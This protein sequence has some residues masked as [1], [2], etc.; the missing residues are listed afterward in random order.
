[1]KK[2]AR[3][4]DGGKH[5]REEEPCIVMG[6][7]LGAVWPQLAGEDGKFEGMMKICMIGWLDEAP[8]RP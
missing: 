4:K 3:A 1:M 6:R 8:G 7:V 2:R 5:E